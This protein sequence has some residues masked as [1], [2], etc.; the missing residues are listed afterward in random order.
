MAVL[1]KMLSNLGSLFD[2]E[3]VELMSRLEVEKAGREKFDGA[4]GLIPHCGACQLSNVARK[5]KT[6]LQM[7]G[8]YMWQNIYANHMYYVLPY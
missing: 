4:K 1:D 3:L 5:M 2:D 7:Q 8:R 6:A